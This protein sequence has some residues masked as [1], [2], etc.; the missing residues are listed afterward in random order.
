MGQRRQS[1]EL[2]LQFLYSYGMNR[3]DRPLEEAITDFWN[4]NRAP[5]EVR[6]F[7]SDLINGTLENL[8]RIDNI[9]REHATNWKLDRIALVDK[10]ILRLAIHEL[11]YR[12]DIPPAVTINEAVEIAK[13]FSTPRSGKFVNGIL[14]KVK[15]KVDG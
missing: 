11:L 2:A 4:S 7:A 9:I 6:Q 13:K 10:N 1:R 3:S 12:D 15:K 14:D 8:E 5:E